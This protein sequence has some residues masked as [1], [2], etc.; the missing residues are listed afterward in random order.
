MRLTYALVGSNA[1]AGPAPARYRLSVYVNVNNL[2]DHANYG[3]YSGVMT[4]PF[5]MQ[6]TLVNNPR[7]VDVGMNVG[8]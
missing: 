3:G 4:S 1:Q 2:T 8:F 6:P 7:R 5:F